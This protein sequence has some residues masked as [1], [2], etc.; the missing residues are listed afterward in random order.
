M[1]KAEREA[2][3][4]EIITEIL[5]LLP[6]AVGNL[7]M[8]YVA[9]NKVNKEFYSAHPEFRK[10]TD[11]VASIV[12]D[13]EGVNTFTGYKEVLEKSIPKIKEA[14]R[15][16]QGLSMEEVKKPNREIDLGEL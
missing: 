10:H 6:G 1:D 7:M 11:V 3:K 4:Q 15:L 14:I 2:L 9:L 12:E 5:L 16:K 13:V 8:N